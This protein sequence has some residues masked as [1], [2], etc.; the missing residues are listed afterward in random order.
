MVVVVY[1]SIFFLETTLYVYAFVYS[2]TFS[3]VGIRG[4]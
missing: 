4:I 1:R 3:P 2:S